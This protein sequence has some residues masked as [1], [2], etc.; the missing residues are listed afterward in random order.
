M[1]LGWALH[2]E[3]GNNGLFVYLYSCNNNPSQQITYTT[4]G[5]LQSVANP[6]QYFYNDG[7]ALA[8]G[9]GGDTFLIVP[10]GKGYTIY[11]STVNLYVNTPG[12]IAPP[13][14]LKLSST[15]TVW[16]AMLQ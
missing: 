1:D 8:L 10:S 4:S 12:K 9:P 2:P 3:W 6:G 11:D 13:N 7:G 15:P 16:T 14:Q 5:Q